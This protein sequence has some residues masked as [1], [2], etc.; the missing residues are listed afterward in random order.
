MIKIMMIMIIINSN[1]ELMM[2][3]LSGLWQ[4]LPLSAGLTCDSDK[5]RLSS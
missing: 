3:V 1:I 4:Q 2:L 5:W